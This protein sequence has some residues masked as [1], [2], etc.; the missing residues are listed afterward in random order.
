MD[1]VGNLD[2]MVD[3]MVGKLRMEGWKGDENLPQ[4]WRFMWNQKSNETYFLTEELVRLKS[5]KAALRHIRTYLTADDAERFS[6]F[7]PPMEDDHSLPVGWKMKRGESGKVIFVSPGGR[8]YK[9]RRLALK[10]MVEEEPLVKF[11][12][13][14]MR[15]ALAEE[16]WREDKRLPLDWRVK[17]YKNS[18]LFLTEAA[19]VLNTPMALELIT[20]RG[21][22]GQDFDLFKSVAGFKDW[23]LEE[24]KLLPKGWK[25]K[26][27]FGSPLFVAATGEHFS[28]KISALKFMIE[29]GFPYD[30]VNMK[31]R[32][33][34]VCNNFC[35]TTIQ[36]PPSHPSTTP[37]TL[38][39]DNTFISKVDIM[40]AFLTAEGWKEDRRL[41]KGWMI[42]VPEPSS[43]KHPEEPLKFLNEEAEELN[44]SEALEYMTLQNPSEEDILAFKTILAAA[45]NKIQ[46]AKKKSGPNPKE[47]VEPN[48]KEKVNKE[49]IV[50]ETSREC[51]ELVDEKETK[52]GLGN[53]LE[54]YPGLV[55]MEKLNEDTKTSAE[56][57]LEKDNDLE[58]EEMLKEGT[59][60][61]AEKEKKDSVVVGTESISINLPEGW[62]I[63]N[64]KGA[65]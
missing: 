40:K 42:K 17:I 26:A 22:K 39:C 21:C 13:D 35:S 46:Q 63:G 34:H 6:T 43:T 65:V 29:N 55:A 61:G 14:I 11:R 50:V 33:K 44:A 56:S 18:I 49:E 37:F 36:G 8:W 54:N 28:N 27:G 5:R 3:K 24:N 64:D 12:L 32:F 52:I 31:N 16:G 15:A 48:V 20:R 23:P 38:I 1:Q 7:F 25:T 41:P 45:E 51:G 59:D 62:T 60:V 19:D 57:K 2:E 47:E 58:T 4:G 53:E 9:N 30:E 10:S